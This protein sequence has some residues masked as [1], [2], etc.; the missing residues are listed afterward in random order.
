MILL[1]YVLLSVV[2]DQRNGFQIMVEPD[3]AFALGLEGTLLDI[4]YCGGQ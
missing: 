4:N 3:M 2:F 1:I